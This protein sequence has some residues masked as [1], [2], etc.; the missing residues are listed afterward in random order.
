MFKDM[1]SL[2][3]EYILNISVEPGFVV[4]ADLL[5]AGVHY[6]VLCKLNAADRAVTTI[7]ASYI[8]NFAPYGG[9]C[10]IDRLEG[11]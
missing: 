5:E 1:F 9:N 6:R 8:V 7:P 2:D 4:P 11:R 3:A 10:T